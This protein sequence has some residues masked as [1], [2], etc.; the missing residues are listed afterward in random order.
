M[1]AKHRFMVTALTHRY[2]QDSADKFL[3]ELRQVLGAFRRSLRDGARSAAVIVTR[4][5]AGV[6]RETVCMF[7]LIGLA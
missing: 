7:M 2:R 1:Q 3:D 5:E 6:A 4:A